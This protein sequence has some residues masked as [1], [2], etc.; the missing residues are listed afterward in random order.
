MPVSSARVI[1]FGCGLPP[2][3]VVL[4]F[5]TTVDAFGGL[6]YLRKPTADQA[7]MK[8]DLSTNEY[9]PTTTS[10]VYKMPPIPSAVRRDA[11]IA[12]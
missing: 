12:P 7:A 1:H 4:L 10:S 3:L 5:A 11:R 2:P 8:G 9:T 6:S